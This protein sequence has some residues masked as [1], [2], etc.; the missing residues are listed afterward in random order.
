MPPL[1]EAMT[2]QTQSC[3]TPP[4]LPSRKTSLHLRFGVGLMLLSFVVRAFAACALVQNWRDG[5]AAVLFSGIYLSGKLLFYL[6]LFL[7]GPAALQR[8]P[9][10]RPTR[11][12]QNNR[13]NTN[14]GKTVGVS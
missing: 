2:M 12:R 10:L 1:H 7:A 11:W 6:G 14:S 4:T 8:Y 3:A 13:G 5:H 9:W